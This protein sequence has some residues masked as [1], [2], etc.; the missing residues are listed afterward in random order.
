MFSW[1]GRNALTQ[2]G[3]NDWDLALLKNFGMPWFK[4]EHSQLQ[5][6]WETFNTFNHTQF[7]GVSIG[8]GALTAPGAPCTGENNI[9]NG[10]VSGSRSPR[11]MQLGMKLVF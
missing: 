7:I 10:E 11:V 6:R 5:F 9:G 3:V 8:C 4:G 2:P 1:M